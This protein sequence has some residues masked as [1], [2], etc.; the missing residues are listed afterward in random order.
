MHDQT[1]SAYLFFHHRHNF[2]GDAFSCYILHLPFQYF[3]ELCCHLLRN[4]LNCPDSLRYVPLCRLKGH[5]QVRRQF[6]SFLQCPK[7]QS[8]GS[9]RK[10]DHVFLFPYRN[11]SECQFPFL[12]SFIIPFVFCTFISRLGTQFPTF[13]SK[14]SRS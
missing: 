13:G 10:A 9:D 7:D 12:T 1:D 6:L 5:L 14:K 8:E 11:P 4:F 3:Q 2:Q